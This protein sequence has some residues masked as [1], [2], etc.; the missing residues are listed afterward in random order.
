MY[1]IKVN[2]NFKEIK[3]IDTPFNV[4]FYGNLMVMIDLIDNEH[5]VINA[6]N[7]YGNNCMDEY[8]DAKVTIFKDI[9]AES[10]APKTVKATRLK[11]LEPVGNI[12]INSAHI[13]KPIMAEDGIYYHYSDVCAILNKV[14]KG[15][16]IIE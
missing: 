1:I 10:V 7:G 6:M 8:A 14:K 5:K 15:Q 2:D 9:L 11:V 12:M 13:H 4:D 16:I 3:S